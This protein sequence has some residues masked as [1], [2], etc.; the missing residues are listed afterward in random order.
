MTGPALTAR[1]V[2]V[3]YG[4]DGAFVRAVDGVDLDLHAGQTVGLVGES[5]CGKSTLG[6]ALLGLLPAAAGADGEIMVGDA[7]VLRLPPRELRRMRG[8]R[9]GMIF[10]EPMTRLNPLMRIS[11]H[12]RE[13]LRAHEPSLG[14]PA[15]DRRAL[16]TLGAMGIPPTR[17]DHYPHEFS[18][19]M[20]QR[21]MIAL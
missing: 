5:G 6:R 10:Q 18:G 9:L 16:D 8:P 11:D 1:G 17:F 3:Y 13:A 19:G 20:R 7:D 21:I 12:F 2:R 4:T 15:A 14:R